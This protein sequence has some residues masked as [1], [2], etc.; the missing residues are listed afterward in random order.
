AKRLRS[1]LYAPSVHRKPD[2]EYRE[3]SAAQQSSGPAARQFHPKPLQPK[4]LQPNLLHP[5]PLKA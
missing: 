1:K 3:L 2:A 5:K 4:Q